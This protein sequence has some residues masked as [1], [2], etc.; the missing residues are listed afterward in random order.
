MHLSAQPLQGDGRSFDYN[1]PRFRD[2]CLE[3]IE[4]A[5]EFQRIIINES[6]LKVLAKGKPC[7]ASVEIMVLKLRR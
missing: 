7:A 4:V 3:E 1:N 2:C 5:K 6:L